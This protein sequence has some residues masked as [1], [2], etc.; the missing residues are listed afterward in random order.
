MS[1][2]PRVLRRLSRS[3]IRAKRPPCGATTPTTGSPSTAST[4][5]YKASGSGAIMGY[6]KP[7]RT[8]KAVE[9]QLDRAWDDKWAFNASY[10][11]S[12][13]RGQH[14]RPGELRH[15]LQRHQPGAVLRPPGRERALR[16]RLFNDYRHQI[17]LRGSFK[18]NDMWSF[19][20]T[21]FARS[22]GPITAFGVRWPND[23]RG[24]GGPGEFSGGGSGWLC[25]S[26]TNNCSDWRTRQ[27]VVHA[28]AAR[29]VACRGSLESGR[30]RDL[31]TAGRRTST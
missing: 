14:R 1:R 20:A 31:D 25:D 2:L 22:G 26:P 13:S 17:K 28:R 6:K 9:F 24:A 27:L 7:R 11:W 4:D 30:Q 15:R 10:L 16:R 19:G 21:L 18:L 23:N 5:G 8:Y 3:S 12:K 29:S